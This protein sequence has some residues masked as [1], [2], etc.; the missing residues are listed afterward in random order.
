MRR[1]RT[2][3][4]AMATSIGIHGILVVVLWTTVSLA[5]LRPESGPRDVTARVEATAPLPAPPLPPPPETPEVPLAA[6]PEA[7]AEAPE[8]DPEECLPEE[9]LFSDLAPPRSM[10]SPIALP[11]GPCR[12]VGFASPRR[13]VAA[14]PPPPPRPV[15]RPAPAGP[16]LVA[17]P[18]DGNRPPAYP[19][20]AA[21]SGQEGLVVLLVTVLPD[22]TV[23]DVRVK[24]S[25]GHAT[26]D[27]AAIRA[28]RDWRFRAALKNGRPVQD[29]IEVPVRFTL[30]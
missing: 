21:A 3:R 1:D 12:A 13:K 24:E 6:E 17:A 16:T 15:L 26:L 25:S 7:V 4:T 8:A 14:P 9:P 18:A 19:A 2:N 23:G 11:A 28:V 29:V 30:R 27:R 22:G 5:S 20:P 10:D